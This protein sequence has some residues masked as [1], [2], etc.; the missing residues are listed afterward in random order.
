MVAALLVSLVC[1]HGTDDAPP[2]RP[3][4]KFTWQTATPESQGMSSSKLDALWKDLEARRTTGL[5]IIRNDRIVYEKYAAGWDATRPHYTASLAKSLVGGLSLLIAMDD[6][7][8]APDDLASK[9]IPQWRT[10]PRKSR[11]TIRQLAN[12]SSGIEDAHEEGKSHT[13]LVGWKGA[14]WKRQTP[15]PFT[16]A[17]DEAP[18]LF[19]PGRK[20]HYSNP[21]MAM[22]AYAVTASLKQAPQKDIRSLL[23]EQIMGPIGVP[24][25]EW[26]IGYN[27]TVNVDGLPLVADWGG[28]SY[29]PRAVVRVGRLLLRKGDWDGRQLFRAATLA[30]ALQLAGAPAP[31]RTTGSPYP[32]W[33]LAW[34]LNE[35][36]VWSRVPRDAFGGSGAGNQLLLI[37]PSLNLI[38]VRNGE[39]LDPQPGAD[40]GLKRY[41]GGLEKLLINP[42]IEAVTDKP[43]G[44]HGRAPAPSPYPASPIIKQL[45][46]ALRHTIIQRAK[47]SD[48][49]PLTWADDDHQYTA[50]GDG[51]GFDP[52]VP[53]KLS[54]G[55]A[56]IEGGPER[57]TGI[58]LRSPTGEQRRGDGRAGRKASGMLMVDGILYMW[59]RNAG[60]AQLAWSA[61]HAKSWT[62][63]DWK[64]TTSFGCPT[65]LNFGRNYAGA[66]DDYVY[67][68]SPDAD[69]AY[70][71]GDRMVL[72][73]VPKDQIRKQ[74]AYEFFEGLDRANQPRWTRD[75]QQRG[76]VFTHP[77]HCYRSAITYNAVLKRYLLCQTMPI[78]NPRFRHW[79]GIFDAPEPWG[80][81]TT[82]FLTE[83]WDVKTGESCSFPTKWMS[84][85]GRTLFLVFSGEDTFSVRGA[86]L[87]LGRQRVP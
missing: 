29:T 56:R 4:P 11:I 87:V 28:A 26:S 80:P 12:H 84:A 54:L 48:N 70:A 8:I 21:G 22:L 35:D 78:E 40:P 66:R 1:A 6:G 65:F 71:P 57:F 13:A 18:V 43:P 82:V 2:A 36:G 47:D 55:L 51:T 42:V 33:G 46:W 44:P 49:W 37:V 69:T 23:K 59:V 75:I 52:K 53:E 31:D 19:E 72:A 68:Y 3:V 61:D 14:F 58:N 10:D 62:W 17:R 74:D 83:R 34:H 86:S 63:S 32:A 64:F 7:R 81:W 76:A 27:A 45:N 41:W 38:L 77:G 85:D 67:V 16:L 5:L 73:R 79:L 24:D 30:R 39:V 20:Y 50:Y 9:Y 25:K 15:D 60:N